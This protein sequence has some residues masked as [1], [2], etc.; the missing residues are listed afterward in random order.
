M[1]PL[2]VSKERNQTVENTGFCHLFLTGFPISRFDQLNLF[3]ANNSHSSASLLGESLDLIDMKSYTCNDP[4]KRRYIRQIFF[5]I[6][7]L[8]N[9]FKKGKF[10]K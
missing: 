5:K 4:Q 1:S 2:T 7:S 8:K 9:H 10:A 6:H 3:T